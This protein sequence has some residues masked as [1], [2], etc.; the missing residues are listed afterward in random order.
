MKKKNHF[1]DEKK[2]IRQKEIGQIK[3]RNKKKKKLSWGLAFWVKLT[4]FLIG[5]IR[6][7][8]KK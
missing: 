4:I 1:L 6:S 7:N 2:T 3:K 8:L 5:Q